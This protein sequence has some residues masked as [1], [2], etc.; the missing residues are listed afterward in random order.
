MVARLR[1]ESTKVDPLC[2]CIFSWD[3]RI[4]EAVSSIKEVLFQLAGP[5]VGVSSNLASCEGHELLVA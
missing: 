3:N 5:R 4:P 1:A 2:Q